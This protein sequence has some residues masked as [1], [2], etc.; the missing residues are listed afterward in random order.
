MGA[1]RGYGRDVDVSLE[2]RGLRRTGDAP[3]Y[4]DL[5]GQAVTNKGAMRSVRLNG[6][7]WTK[8]DVKVRL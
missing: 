4:S 8:L 1:Q 3:R 5:K 7:A 6:T 2:R